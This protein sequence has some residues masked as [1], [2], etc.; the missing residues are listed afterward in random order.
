MLTMRAR[1]FV[2]A[3]VL[4]LF[5][6]DAC[7][8]PATLP[9]SNTTPIPTLAPEVGSDRFVIA[10]P[11]AVKVSLTLPI[12]MPSARTGQTLYEANC[13][14]CHGADGRG[15]VPGA[16]NFTD[17]DYMRGES[18]A[19]FFT[20]VSEGRGEMPAFKGALSADDRWNVVYYVWRFS[21]TD[22]TLNQG[23]QIYSA[24]CAACHGAN[25]TGIVLGAAD[26]TNMTLMAN[27]APRDFYQIVT[28][29]KGSMPAWQGRLSQDKRW[30]VIDFIGTFVY[31][32]A[33]PGAAQATQAVPAETPTVEVAC[34]TTQPNPFKW[35]DAAAVAAGQAVFEENC[36]LCHGPDGK[37]TLPGAPDFTTMKAQILNKPG[38]AFC[39]IANGHGDQMPS[40]KDKLTT[41]QMWQVLTYIA[42]LGK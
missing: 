36:I 28:Q 40:W 19:N 18:P 1:P 10:R 2:L 7:A 6:L 15:A 21:T 11:T 25:G 29:G 37:G 14:K 24:N 38:E 5:V 13:A 39:I 8:G 31:D 32:P 26:F 23:K 20:I 16:R 27:S 41:E 33:L 35:D 3:A 34:T 30:A 9:T 42:T 12:H 17:T 22:Q 4:L